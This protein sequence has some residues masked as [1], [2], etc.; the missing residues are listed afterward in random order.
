MEGYTDSPWGVANQAPCGIQRA[1]A[2]MVP[3]GLVSSMWPWASEPAKENE[4]L[5]DFSVLNVVASIRTLS[6]PVKSESLCGVGTAGRLE[7][8]VKKAKAP[9]QATY[10]TARGPAAEA[11][12][13]RP[14]RAHLGGLG[15]AL[16]RPVPSVGVACP[17][18]SNRPGLGIKGR[19]ATE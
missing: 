5:K 9:A 14:G 18:S 11:F 17:A 2:S 4:A 16:P 6:R 12:Q 13:S 19:S 8:A 7:Q 15:Q 10:A 1:W 3:M